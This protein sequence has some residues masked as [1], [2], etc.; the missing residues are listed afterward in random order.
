MSLETTEAL[1]S[2]SNV[3]TWEPPDRVI[4]A[5]YGLDRGDILRFD[6]NTSPATPAFLAEALQGPFDPPLNEYPDSTYAEPWPRR[7]LPT[8]VPNHSRSSSAAARTRCST[9]SPRP[10]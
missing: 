9:S 7:P 8:S 6:L 10:T 2:T 1:A 3:Y 4:A 5:R